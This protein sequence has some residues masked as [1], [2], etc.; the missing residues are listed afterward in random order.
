[1]L[2]LVGVGPVVIALAHGAVFTAHEW[3]NELPHRA[4]AFR[5]L[6]LLMSDDPEHIGAALLVIQKDLSGAVSRAIVVDDYLYGT[7]ELLHKEAVEGR[8]DVIPLVIGN[9]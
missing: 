5:E 9:A 3:N 1:M 8:R 7:V 2:K 4:L 6:V